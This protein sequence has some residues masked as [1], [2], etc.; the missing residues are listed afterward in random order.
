MAWSCHPARGRCALG[1][2]FPWRLRAKLLLAMLAPQ[3]GWVN[4]CGGALWRTLDDGSVEVD[5]HGRWKHEPGSAG[6]KTLETTYLNW[7]REFH[8]VARQ[9]DVPVSWLVAIAANETGYLASRP[10]Y[11]RTV[12]RT[13]PSG[14]TSVGIMQPLT[15]TAAALGF[16]PSQLGD[17]FTNIS[18]G[19]AFMLNPKMAGKNLA[20]GFP[21]VAATYNAGH[22]CN[23]GNDIFNTAGHKGAYVTNAIKFLNTAIINMDVDGY[24]SSGAARMGMGLGLGIV[25]LGVA[26]AVYLNRG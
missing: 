4:P 22:I 6:Y 7:A 10:D 21:A 1:K 15:V 9:Y 14:V 3:A 24:S 25:G 17:A 12:S 20:Y 5:G 2:L 26:V 23:T 8:D 13:E 18:V 16:D 11:Q 19:A